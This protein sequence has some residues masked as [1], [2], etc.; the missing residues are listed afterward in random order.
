MPQTDLIIFDLGR[1]LVDFDFKKVISKLKRHSP[2]SLKEIHAYFQRTPLWD[3]FERG[4][5]SPENFYKELQKDLKLKGLTFEGFGPVWNEIFTENHDTVALLQSLR[6]KYRLALLSNVNFMHWDYI[7]QRY[8]FL[9]WFDYLITSCAV[10]HRKP[11]AEIFRIALHLA[12]V[13]P[14][15]A[16]FID[17]VASHVRAAQ[18]MGIRAHQFHNA[19]HLRMQLDGIWL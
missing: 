2:L 4:G 8:G 18:S 1:V 5:V 10:G 17:D 6:G 11:D 15:R 16:I 19:T 9:K 7:H 14:E 3:R 13:S 12:G